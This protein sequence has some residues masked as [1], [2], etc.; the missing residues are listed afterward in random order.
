MIT[1]EKNSVGSFISTSMD[2]YFGCGN[3]LPNSGKDH[4]RDG[5]PISSIFPSIK[6]FPKLP[7]KANQIIAPDRYRP[8]E[9]FHGAALYP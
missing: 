6:L 5:L 4:S 9:A 3:M 1:S 7:A 2:R 8:G